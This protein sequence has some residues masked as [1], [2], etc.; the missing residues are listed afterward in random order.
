MKKAYAWAI[1]SAL[2]M[3]VAWSVQVGA[4][5]P[6]AAKPSRDRVRILFNVPVDPTFV[7]DLM[8]FKRLN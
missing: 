5:G 6:G 8:A 3:T 2:T 1:V 7:P 4:Q